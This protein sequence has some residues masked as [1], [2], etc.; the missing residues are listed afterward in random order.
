MNKNH[1]RGGFI[2]SLEAVSSGTCSRVVRKECDVQFVTVTI[3]H[4]MQKLP[5]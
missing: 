4:I 5:K 1:F 2:T 3:E